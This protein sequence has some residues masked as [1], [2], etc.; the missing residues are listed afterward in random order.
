MAQEE[1][2]EGS[3]L[4]N[5]VDKVIGWGRAMYRRIWPGRDDWRAS[6]NDGSSDEDLGDAFLGGMG[7][8][9]ESARTEMAGMEFNLDL[10]RERT[11]KRIQ[12]V[13]G[14]HGEVGGEPRQWAVLYGGENENPQTW[15]PN[16]PPIALGVGEIDVCIEP[17]KV[18]HLQ[19]RIVFPA[20]G[21]LPPRLYRSW[22]ISDIKLR[23][24]RL[25]GLWN[26]W[27]GE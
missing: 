12:V 23:E 3:A 8:T 9:W 20:G 14:L 1:L 6:A 15:K 10:G 27:I 16:R 26:S 4:I 22:K 7:I 18:R 17:K 5:A 11:L 2:R 13:E 25:F 24:R 21:D 19:F